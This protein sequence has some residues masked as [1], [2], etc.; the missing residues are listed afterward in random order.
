MDGRVLSS[1]T[2][3]RQERIGVQVFTTSQV[4]RKVLMATAGGIPPDIAGLMCSE[5]VPYADK[6]ALVPLDD[7]A[8]AVGIT[9]ERYI[10]RYWDLCYYRGH[11]WALPSTVTSLALHWNKRLFR[12]AGLDPEHPPETIEQLDDYADRLTRRDAEGNITQIGFMPAEPG[13][14]PTTGARPCRLRRHGGQDR[15]TENPWH[16]RDSLSAYSWSFWCC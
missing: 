15:A 4:Q 8:G 11:L 12:E 1:P 16:W 3:I 7:Y 14:W 5:V 9:S 2:W 10:S 6:N 13:W